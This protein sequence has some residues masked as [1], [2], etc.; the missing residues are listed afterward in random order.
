MIYAA[1][2]TT[3]TVQSL[4]APLLPE[5]ASRFSLSS[6]E[7]GA[8]LSATAMATLLV[9]VP[10]GALAD[11]F[12]VGN[13]TVSAMAAEVA[14]SL[15]QAFAPSYLVLLGARVLFGVG[16]G[17]VWTVGLAWLGRTDQ[18]ASALGPTQAANGLG[19]VAG[20]ALAGVLAEKVGTAAPFIAG[21]ALLGVLTVLLATFRADAATSDHQPSA[22][23]S[24]RSVAH[25]D[26]IWPLA[27]VVGAGI[28]GGATT[29]LVPIS[30]HRAGAS[31]GRIGLAFSAAAVFFIM[32][33]L[34]TVSFGPRAIRTRFVVLMTLLPATGSAGDPRGHAPL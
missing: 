21:G 31:V 10:A 13:L 27:A 32:A 16:Y 22:L 28:A 3:S 20:P 26:V 6:L 11:R 24:L 18:S 30:L 5:Y 1:I 4:I 7:L 25:P 2:V 15:L 14:G 8:L 29:L 12:G 19:S 23:V 34:V 33:S 17:V 9:S